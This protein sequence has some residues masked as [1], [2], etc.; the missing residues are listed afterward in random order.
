M[1]H[2]L[3]LDDDNI[4]SSASSC[5]EADNVTVCEADVS[6]SFVSWRFSDTMKYIVTLPPYDIVELYLL[7]FANNADFLNIP[8]PFPKLK[9]CKDLFTGDADEQA[10]KDVYKKCLGENGLNQLQDGESPV[11]GLY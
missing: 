1:I 4:F 6:T 5:R 9:V 11:L 7:H 10:R 3:S 2:F 8:D